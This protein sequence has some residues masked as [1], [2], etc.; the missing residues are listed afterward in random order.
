M[1]L[2]FMPLLPFRAGIMKYFFV[3]IIMLIF[4]FHNNIENMKKV[5]IIVDD[6][7]R[8]LGPLSL[9]SIELKKLELSRFWYS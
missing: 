9:L 5:A 8:D 4:I 6:V 3:I 7:I 1:F 2:S